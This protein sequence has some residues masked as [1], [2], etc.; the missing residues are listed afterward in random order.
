MKVKTRSLVVVGVAVMAVLAL[1]GGA[2]RAEAGG[3]Q[4]GIRRIELVGPG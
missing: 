3:R 2:E 4:T 1:L